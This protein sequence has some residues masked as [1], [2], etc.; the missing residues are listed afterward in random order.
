LERTSGLDPSSVT[1]A[2]RYIKLFTV[3]SVWPFS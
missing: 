1:V 3:S 2:P